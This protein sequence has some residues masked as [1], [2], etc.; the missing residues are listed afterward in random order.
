MEDALAEVDDACKDSQ[1]FDAA[2]AALRRVV[3]STN[4]GNLLIIILG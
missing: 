3:S 2:K 1:F 4:E